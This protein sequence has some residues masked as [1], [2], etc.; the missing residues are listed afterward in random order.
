LPHDH[1]KIALPSASESALPYYCLPPACLSEG[2]SRCKIPGSIAI[3]LSAPEFHPAF[4][5]SEQIALVPVPE[6]AMNQND[7]FVA[8]QYNVWF[9]GKL[10]VVEAVSQPCS[11]QGLSN[12]DFRLCIVSPDG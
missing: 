11:E 8:S 4:R 2:L 5:P 6:A 3:K 12:L 9:A 10:P 1:R 7:R